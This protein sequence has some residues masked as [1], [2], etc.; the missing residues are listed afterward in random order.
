MKEEKERWVQ[1][2]EQAAVEQDPQ[3]LVKL[4]QE[5]IRLFEEKKER[6]QRPPEGDAV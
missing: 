4:V 1:L 3:R 6:R 2:C 5:I